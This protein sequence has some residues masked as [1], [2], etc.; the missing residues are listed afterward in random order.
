MLRVLK[1]LNELIDQTFNLI[2]LQSNVRGNASIEIT[3][4]SENREALKGSQFI[5]FYRLLI[6]FHA[7]IT[8]LSVLSV[9]CSIVVLK[10]LSF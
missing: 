10:L 6:L 5:I 4:S 9:V 8:G 3:Y 1:N 2:I 7:E